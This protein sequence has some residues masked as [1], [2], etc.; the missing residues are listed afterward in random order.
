[1]EDCVMEHS[2]SDRTS[3]ALSLSLK[4]AEVRAFQPHAGQNKSIPLNQHLK[5]YG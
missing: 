2:K 5:K 4:V 3:A 1:M